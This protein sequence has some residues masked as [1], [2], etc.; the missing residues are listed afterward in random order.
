MTQTA[1]GE[2]LGVTFQ[3]I[4]KYENGANALAASQLPAVC[5]ALGISPNA[6][7]DFDDATLDAVPPSASTATWRLALQ[8]E[9]LSPVLRKAVRTSGIEQRQCPCDS[10]DRCPIVD[11]R[12]YKVEGRCSP[13]TGAAG[14]LSG[15]LV[16]SDNAGVIVIQLQDGQKLPPYLHGI[17]SLG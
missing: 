13:A 8:I 12:S 17:R 9:Q 5:E 2:R 7:L 6:L 15:D 11:P 16:I 1:L 4:Q 14:A 3:Q 10:A